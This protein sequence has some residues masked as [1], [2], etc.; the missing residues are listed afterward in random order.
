MLGINT[1]LASQLSRI[2]SFLRLQEFLGGAE[3][4]GG[5][6][7]VSIRGEGIWNPPTHPENRDRVDL[8]TVDRSESSAVFS[9]CATDCYWQ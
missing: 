6:G 1:I 4:G 8:L 3:G 5:K 2:S 9:V 7:G